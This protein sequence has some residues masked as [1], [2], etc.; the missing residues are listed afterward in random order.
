[1]PS[2]IPAMRVSGQEDLGRQEQFPRAS[3][4]E[5]DIK[6]QEE[7]AVKA[8]D[9]DGRACIQ[10]GSVL[11]ILLPWFLVCV[12]T[13]PKKLRGTWKP[14]CY[15]VNPTPRNPTKA[16]KGVSISPLGTRALVELGS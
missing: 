13:V 5:A 9:V 6:K 3:D 2:L 10:T 14:L 12:E 8:G 15:L 1:M 4:I 11:E 7:S 16:V